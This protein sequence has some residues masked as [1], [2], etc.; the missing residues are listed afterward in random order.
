MPTFGRAKCLIAGLTGALATLVT[1]S[2]A[3]PYNETY[4]DY[5]LNVNQDATSV[6]EYATSRTNTTYTPSPSN[7]R[8]IPFYTVL[9]DKFADGDPTNNNYFNI[10]YE[11]DWR[12]TQ[13]RFGGDVKGLQ[14]KLDYLQGMGVRGIYV[15]GTAFLNMPWQADSYSPLD[16]SVLDPHWGTKADWIAFIDEVHARNMY[17]MMDFTIGTMGDMIGFSG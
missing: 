7:W 15:A 14:S 17:F 5:N 12:E 2:S 13:M 4:A 6:V 10:M 9:L 8:Q 3:A 16:F 11:H 1:L